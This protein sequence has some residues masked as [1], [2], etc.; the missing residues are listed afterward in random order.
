MN[1]RQM[2]SLDQDLTAFLT[3]MVDGMGRPERLLRAARAA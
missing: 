3:S 2:K 1:Q